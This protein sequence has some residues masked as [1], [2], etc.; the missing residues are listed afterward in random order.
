MLVIAVSLS[1]FIGGLKYGDFLIY[2]LAVYMVFNILTPVVLIVIDLVKYF[3]NRGS[4]ISLKEEVMFEEVTE[5]AEINKLSKNKRALRRR[6]GKGKIKI[7]KMSGQKER[8][9]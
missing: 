3:K 8:E 6:A 5:E 7:K 1:H 9:K 4:R 2:S